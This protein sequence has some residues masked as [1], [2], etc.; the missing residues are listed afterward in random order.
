MT[1]AQRIL[2]LKRKYI[3]TPIPQFR[4]AHDLASLLANPPLLALV[5]GVV[6]SN[7][8]RALEMKR[9]EPIKPTETVIVATASPRFFN[10]LLLASKHSKLHLHQLSRS[11]TVDDHRRMA[12]RFPNARWIYYVTGPITGRLLQ[13]LPPS[14]RQRMIVVNTLTT[15]NVRDRGD[16][17][18]VIDLFTRYAM[19]GRLLA[20]ALFEDARAAFEPLALRKPS[21]RSRSGPEVTSELN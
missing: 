12:R 16:Y 3:L 13:R 6:R 17:Q 4:P 21:R 1:A 14:I 18:D 20:P 10:D 8:N 19:M 2:D 5:E 11:Q 9:F 15:G 7:V